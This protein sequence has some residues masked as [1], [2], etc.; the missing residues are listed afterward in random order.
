MVV[1]KATR[2]AVGWVDSKVIDSAGETVAWMGVRLVAPRDCAR[3][4]SMAGSMDGLTDARM[5]L[6]RA[7]AKVASMET[8]PAA[9]LAAW[10]GTLMVGSWG[11]SLVVMTAAEMAASLVDQRAIAKAESLADV[12]DDKWAHR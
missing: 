5:A 7:C 2:A 8:T 4:V 1:S 10:L 12:W 6:L 9:M 11:A 3:A